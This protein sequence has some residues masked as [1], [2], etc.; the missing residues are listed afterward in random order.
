MF[1]CY[2]ANGMTLLSPSPEA[3]VELL[4][5]GCAYRFKVTGLADVTGMKHIRVIEN[6]DSYRRHGVTYICSNIFKVPAR[7]QW[8]TQA[9]LSLTS[10]FISLRVRQ[11][12]SVRSY[13]AKHFPS[14]LGKVVS[15]SI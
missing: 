6:S 4:V 11:S 14:D 1:C 12:A 8:T 15:V 5:Y 3:F 10:N 2:A 7:S 13:L 9:E